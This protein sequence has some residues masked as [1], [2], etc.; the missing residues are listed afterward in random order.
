MSDAD[1]ELVDLAR[2]R[3][4]A[5][6]GGKYRIDELVGIGGMAAVYVATAPNGAQFAVKMLHPTLSV[7]AEMR[8]RFVLEGHAANS[9][10]H[11]GFVPVLDDDG[12]EDG[13]AF[14]VMELLVGQSVEEL[15]Q[16]HG[17]RLPPEVALAIG[18]ELCDVLV[19][20]GPVTVAIDEIAVTTSKRL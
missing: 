13:N 3:I 16:G 11:P 5:R 18:R 9:V 17:G 7:R 19:G 8:K 15:W 12:A 6:L 1:L 14:L 20:D 4:G 2:S 10:K